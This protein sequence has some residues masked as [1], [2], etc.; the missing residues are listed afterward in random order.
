MEVTVE[1][2]GNREGCGFSSR[3][4][5]GYGDVSVDISSR[6]LGE[7]EGRKECRL[8]RGGGEPTK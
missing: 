3:W 6:S 8:G 1:L 2:G 4:E 7:R 5:G